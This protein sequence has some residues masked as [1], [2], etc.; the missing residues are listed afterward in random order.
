MKKNKKNIEDFILKNL[1]KINKKY[2]NLDKS[3]NLFYQ[4]LD[5]LDFM[6]LIFIIEKKFNFQ[7]KSKDLSKIRTI[8]E[9]SNY[10]IKKHKPVSKNN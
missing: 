10:I 4:H 1:L 2:K 5:S 8:N 7:F 9:I 6:K 3:N